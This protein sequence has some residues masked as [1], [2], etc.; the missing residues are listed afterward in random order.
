[1][2]KQFNPD[3]YYE[4]LQSLEIYHEVFSA[5]WKISRPKFTKEVDTAAVGF[6]P[7][8]G[9][10]EF[11]INPDYF[12]NVSDYTKEFIICH[13]ML[14]VIL[15][16]GIRTMAFR[17]K[18]T[19]DTLNIALD[20]AVNHLLTKSFGF[21]R[22]MIDD[23]KELC[24]ADTVFQELDFEPNKSFE[25]YITKI[26][27]NLT[28]CKVKIKVKSHDHLSQFNN[29]AQDVIGK[30]IN[31]ILGQ[32]D[33]KEQKKQ[34]E[35]IN[36]LLKNSNGVSHADSDMF[37]LFIGNNL[38]VKKIR[39]WESVLNKYIRK[40]EKEREIMQW[41][42]LNRR[43]A[44]FKSSKMFLPSEAE[45][46]DRDFYK[47]NI[48]LFL[49]YSGSCAGLKDLFFAASKTFD[50][51]IFKVKKFAHTTQVAEFKGDQTR[52]YGGG[53]T[54][55]CIENYIQD[56][57]RNEK[58]KNYPD[59]I[60]HFTDGCGDYFTSQ[61]PERWYVFL[62]HNSKYCFPDKTNF[63]KLEDFVENYNNRSRYAG[64]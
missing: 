60:F 39:R 41:I 1:M 8:G 64:W 5:L 7:S 33:E 53:T 50:P 54:F 55:S 14:H 44:F 35:K 3:D 9:C 24:W 22:Y 13:E 58:I 32:L 48:W 15:A 2:K 61:H 62:T 52:V 56:Q 10:I 37:S 42:R 11:L 63:F 21:N 20:L 28:K 30:A 34:K 4:L 57:I 29:Q 26:Q 38:E 16:H 47:Y 36:D 49:D 43:T 27:E 6:D 59:A 31:N 19:P 45:V 12:S 25:Y 23:W 18:Y 17:D 40:S 51:R 46:I